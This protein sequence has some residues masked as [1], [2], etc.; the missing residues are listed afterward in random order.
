MVCYLRLSLFDSGAH[1]YLIAHRC[2]EGCQS[3]DSQVADLLLIVG[4]SWLGI[5]VSYV[6]LGITVREV[7]RT[8]YDFASAWLVCGL[9]C[10]FYWSRLESGSW[11]TSPPI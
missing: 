5:T 1:T 10:V 3:A 7:L 6:R 2:H 8:R 4:L 11:L 9:T